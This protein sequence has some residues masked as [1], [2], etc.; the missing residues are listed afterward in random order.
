MKAHRRP[1]DLGIIE[2]KH[3]VKYLLP[4]Y[5]EGGDI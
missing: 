1:D 5:V 4:K 3:K 2:Q